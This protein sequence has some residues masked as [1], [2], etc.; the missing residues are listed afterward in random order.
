MQCSIYFQNIYTMILKGSYR[1]KQAHLIC[2]IQSDKSKSYL[3]FIY[4]SFLLFRSFSSFN[5]LI[6]FYIYFIFCKYVFFFAFFKLWILVNSLKVL[7]VF[8]ITTFTKFYTLFLEKR[9]SRFFLFY[10]MSS[11][12]TLKC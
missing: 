8:Y 1:G 10:Y 4:N 3:Y 12:S 5:Y 2:T 6:V 7:R 11:P 9:V